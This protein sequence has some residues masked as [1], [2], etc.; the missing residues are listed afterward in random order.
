MLARC[1]TIVR[2]HSCASLWEEGH[3]GLNVK[4]IEIESMQLLAKLLLVVPPIDLCGHL[5]L[6]ALMCGATEVMSRFCVGLVVQ[7]IYNNRS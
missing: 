2:S 6:D 3:T 1:R 5:G 4:Y 7:I